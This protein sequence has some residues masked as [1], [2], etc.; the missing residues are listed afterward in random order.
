MP[1]RLLAG[2]PCSPVTTDR[3]KRGRAS[4]DGATARIAIAS[5]AKGGEGVGH[6]D[7]PGAKQAVFVPRTAPG[8]LVD[9]RM[10]RAAGALRGELIRIVEPSPLRVTPPCP[11]AETCGGCDLMH[12]SPE[13]QRT[14]RVEVVRNLVRPIIG[15]VELT[16]HDAPSLTAY[17]TRVRLAIEHRH[18]RLLV[19][20]RKPS[21]HDIVAV[22][23]CIV[24]LEAV[25]HARARLAEWLAGSTGRGE[26]SV[27]VGEGGRPAIRLSWEGALSPSVFARGEQK[28]S[29]GE[30]A[31]VQV[32]LP[33]ARQP[34][35]IGDPRSLTMAMDGQPLWAPPG[36][37]T[38]AFGEMNAALATG[39]VGK[40]EAGGR[41]VLELFSGSGNFSVGLARHTTELETVESDPAAVEAARE[42]LAAR[43][44]SARVRCSDADA[45]AI[46]DDVRVVVLDPPRSG[47]PG[48]SARVA[49]SRVRRVVMVSCDPATLA[50]DLKTLT[51]GRFRVSSFDMFEMFPQTSHIEALVVLDRVTKA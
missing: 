21:S 9:V 49:A 24:A 50:R 7:G 8:D 28:V 47:A 19:G 3:R 39:V 51:A 2:T 10:R 30:W 25:D 22:D 38:Q 37:F 4:G 31:G 18:G 23:R 33:G 48:A 6:L 44:L 32:E 26:A 16:R 35:V 46:R 13:A 1:R 43:G 15:D 29:Q 5:L 36:G 34:A 12:V 20:F 27:A 14:L 17:R 45:Y 40:A 41:R 11:H 42:N